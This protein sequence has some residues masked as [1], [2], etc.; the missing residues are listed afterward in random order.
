M[1]GVP[2][3]QSKF[4]EPKAL[5]GTRGKN[6]YRTHVRTTRIVGRE[7]GHVFEGACPECGWEFFGK[8][9]EKRKA[10]FKCREC[11]FTSF[12]YKGF[13]DP[14]KDRTPEIRPPEQ[15]EYTVELWHATFKYSS[16][17]PKEYYGSKEWI[18][19]KVGRENYEVIEEPSVV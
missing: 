16:L 3:I 18:Q 8:R 19:E 15:S 5:G 1:S 4:L 13:W 9:R 6:E 2:Y 11:G 10:L 12:L 17:D 7:G 14:R